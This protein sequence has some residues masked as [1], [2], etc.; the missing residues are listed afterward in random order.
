MPFLLLLLLSCFAASAAPREPSLVR[1][2]GRQLIV[3]KRLPDGSLG[4]AEPFAMRGVNWSPSSRNTLTSPSDPNNVAVRRPE[5]AKWQQTDLPLIAA[6][7]ANT[8]RVAMDFGT[9]PADG[10]SGL[11]VLDACWERGIMVVMTVDSGINDT[12]NARDVVAFYRSHPA[13]LMWSLGNEWNF[14]R[15]YGA[16]SSI[17]DAAR[18]TETAA[19]IVK[20]LDPAHPVV[21][22][23]GEIDMH[24]AGL[25]LADAADYINRVCKSVDVWSLNIYRGRS[26]GAL[27]EQWKAISP[28]PM[29]LGEFGIDAFRSSVVSNP[30]PP[31]ALD[32]AQ[33]ADWD[34]ALWRHLAR[35]LSAANPNSAAIGGCV[36][37]FNDQ[38]W[39]LAPA[40]SQQTGGLV[41]DAF[42]DG[43]SSEEIF[44]ICDIDRKPRQA[45][46]ALKSAYNPVNAG[47]GKVLVVSSTRADNSAGSLRQAIAQASDGDTIVFDSEVS[48][49][50]TLGSE[51]SINKSIHI[52]GPGTDIVTISGNGATRVFNIGSNAV[53]RISALSI[54]RGS[55][56]EM[57]AAILNRGSLEVAECRFF[58]NVA[59]ASA[60]VGQGGAIYNSGWLL[61]ENCRFQD[62]RATGN[63]GA[64]R[65]SGDVAIVGS[66]F[67]NNRCD[68]FGGS[69]YNLAAGLVRG[70]SFTG[71]VAG[72]GAAIWNEDEGLGVFGSTLNRNTTAGQ[73]AGI[74]SKN[75]SVLVFN[76]TFS[77]NN[78]TAGG[79]AILSGAFGEGRGMLHLFNSTVVSNLAAGNQPG[80]GVKILSGGA[81]IRSSLV[82]GNN[83]SR[84]ADFADLSGAFFSEGFNVVGSGSGATGLSD[85]AN[86]DRVGTA[87]ARLDPK[88]GPLRD[89]GGGLLT[90]ALAHGSPALDRGHS[91]W[92]FADERGVARFDNASLSNA[93]GGDGSDVGA[94]EAGPLRIEA[95]QAGASGS[96][97]V[98]GANLG[99]DYAIESRD[100]LG[101]G[102]WTTVAAPLA[103]NGGVLETNLALGGPRR[104]YRILQAAPA[105]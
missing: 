19:A 69:L 39:K 85:G 1:V 14:N 22:S 24:Q 5:Y 100:A 30:N 78:A 65:S 10:A 57:G 101:T 90:H 41:S 62:N 23:F 55:N 79:G 96:R 3:Q 76:S 68:F 13:I 36:H 38:W 35:N 6:M 66:S 34:A 47:G 104:F 18:R 21:S 63:G 74:A 82:A 64:I 28:K 31:G 45:Y 93:L 11:A 95:F 8:V 86:A 17:A 26:F 60:G 37:E 105:N 99:I 12:S 88:V 61:A 83:W 32:E 67:S 53:V 81:A 48:G 4:P 87:A 42:P 73:G 59:G 92:P 75:G 91:F 7:N 54:G 27:F 15:Y 16:A 50:I 97:L 80:G 77:S 102:A 20:A 52:A 51:L 94:Y 43:M 58:S 33:Q 56:A 98:F 70:C 84:S 44:G 72:N 71:S 2:D 89:N 49:T 103:G 40:T 25:R 29:F 9:S 46:E